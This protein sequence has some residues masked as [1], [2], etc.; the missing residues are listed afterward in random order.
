MDK[1]APIAHMIF[2]SNSFLFWRK[3]I[4]CRASTKAHFILAWTNSISSIIW[5]YE[6]WLFTYF[7]IL[8]EL[9]KIRK[10]LAER[11]WQ[12][13]LLKTE[14]YRNPKKNAKGKNGRIEIRKC[15]WRILFG[16]TITFK[17]KDSEPEGDTWPRVTIQTMPGWI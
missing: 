10:R 3:F 17:I 16:K 15:I 11:K 8:W 1:E 14:C 6:I 4:W 13:I 9:E 2:H 12:P 5:Y 7:K